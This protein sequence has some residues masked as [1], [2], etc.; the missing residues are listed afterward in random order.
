ME[1]GSENNRLADPRLLKDP[2]R[3]TS[4]KSCCDTCLPAMLLAAGAGGWVGGCMNG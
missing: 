3:Q 1:K 4:H 2:S